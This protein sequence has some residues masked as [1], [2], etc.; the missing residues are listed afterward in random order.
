[1]GNHFVSKAEFDSNFVETINLLNKA[2]VPYWVCHGTLLGLIRDGR[3]IP[4]DHDIDIALWAGDFSKEALIE[5]MLKNGFRLKNDGSDYDFVAFFKTGGREVDFNY[6][7]VQCNSDIAF[8]EWYISK[9]ILASCVNR[10]AN[11]VNRLTS[12]KGFV[13]RLSFLGSLMNHFVSYLKKNG[14]FYKSAGYTTPLSLLM[15]FDMLENSEIQVRKPLHSEKVLEF[16]YGKDWRQPKQKY[17]WTT[18]SPATRISN[19]RF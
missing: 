11:L 3:L 7:R 18:E 13:S 14:H 19:S 10:I 17:D 4:W 1:M 6:Y 5:L 8:S 16:V 15:D 12:G 9:S 2:G